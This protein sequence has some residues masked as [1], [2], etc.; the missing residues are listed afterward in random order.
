LSDLL[1]DRIVLLFLGIVQN[2][3]L[4]GAVGDR[5]IVQ[6]AIFGLRT[7]LN[8]HVVLCDTLQHIVALADIDKLII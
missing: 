3:K 7:V 1:C 6:D 2:I 4:Y 8:A 5:H